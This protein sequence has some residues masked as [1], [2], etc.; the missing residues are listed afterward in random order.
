MLLVDGGDFAE[1]KGF[2]PWE[3]TEFMWE[4]MGRLGYDVVTPADR[5]LQYGREAITELYGRHPEI[6]IVSANI[7]DKSGNPVWEPYTLVEKAGVKIAVTG[8][9]GGAPY[10]FNL[11][12]GDFDHDDFSFKDSKEIL[13]TLVPEMRQQADLVV[14]LLHE[15]P[16]DAR[17]IIDEIPGMDVVIVGHSPG[18]M[19]NPDRIAN[20]LM[21][22][23]GNRGQYLP[24]T[25]L[26]LDASNK[27]IDYG[28]EGKPLAKTV[29]KDEAIDKVVMDFEKDRKD[30]EAEAKRK[31]AVDKAMLRGTETFLGAEACAR[32]HPDEYTA[33]AATAHFAAQR[34]G[35]RPEDA[36]APAGLDIANVQ[37]EH[38][39][40]LGTFHGTPGMET[41]VQ[42]AI[43]RDCH[44]EEGAPDFD[45]KAALEA[46]QI[47]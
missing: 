17:R 31:E 4:M 30:R 46:G 45:Y 36:E 37:C 5:E 25:E 15:T 10:S 8:V 6:A 32:C 24:V 13:R 42:E 11:T 12:R 20:T 35:A 28:G 26:I 39:H 18:Y 21:V 38:C 16:V 1:T 29:A 34:T 23:G 44:I 22:R 41:K 3:K 14:V 2:E 27:V 9:T 19:F 43:C 40:G 33:W 7:T 47:H